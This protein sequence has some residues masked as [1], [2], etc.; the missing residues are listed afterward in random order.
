[1]NDEVQNDDPLFDRLV[2]GELSA[3]ERQQLLASLDDRP[4]GWR[5]CALAFLE[6]QTWRGEMRRVVN[7]P[8]PF[9]KLPASSVQ[10]LS[11][12]RTGRSKLAASSTWL[13]TAASLLLAFG[14]GWRMHAPAELDEG[15]FIVTADPAPAAN[16]APPLAAPQSDADSITL[17]V[18]DRD[19]RPQRLQVPLVE[20]DRLGDQFGASPHWA[21]P[22][23]R[24]QLADRG[25]DLQTRR[26][27][28]PLFF[29]QDSRIVPMVVPVDDA[30]VTPV[31]RPI[32]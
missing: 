16:D 19:G 15:D 21:A 11:A 30:L 3:L 5:R 24:R 12:K 6:A 32:Y 4:G 18:H 27:Y 10:P 13:A 25:I 17:V 1:M 14:L 20:G 29:E 9:T 23:F 26:R 8:P 2:D 7:E 31:N 28:A 22:D